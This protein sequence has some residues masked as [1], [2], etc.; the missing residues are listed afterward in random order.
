MKKLLLGLLLMFSTGLFA[1]NADLK[2]LIQKAKTQGAT[3]TE[4]Q[5][6][7]AM[8]KATK[9][10]SPMMK[11]FSELTKKAKKAEEDGDEEA[12]AKLMQEIEKI[13]AKYKEV[14]TLLEEFDA[15][16]ESNAIAK[17]LSADDVFQDEM[18][19]ELG[20]EDLQSL[21]IIQKEL[22]DDDDDD[23]VTEKETA[24]PVSEGSPE[25]AKLIEKAKAEGGTWNEEQWKKAFRETIGYMSPMMKEISALS[26]KAEALGDKEDVAAMLKFQKE[27]EAI[28]AKF[29]GVA[30]Q[31]EE[32]GKVAES[33]EIGKKLSND[34]EFEKELFKEFG[35]DELMGGDK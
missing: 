6:K 25:L 32:F 21:D 16:C 27:A 10:M 4:A 35:L 33:F 28:Q 17:K 7:D 31:I 11:E 22:S 14:D 18:L 3:W 24:A 13:D 20:L 19:K 26:K 15:I 34:D 30:E 9:A 2:D 1:Q 29:G 8:K 23:D 12:I 5:W